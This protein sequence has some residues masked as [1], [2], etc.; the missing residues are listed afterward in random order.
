MGLDPGL[1]PDLPEAVY[2]GDTDS[3]SASSMKLILKSPAQYHY[4]LTH[5]EEPKAHFDVGH[6][7]HAK[8]LGAGA[9]IAVIDVKDKRG[10]AWTEPAEAARAEGK[11]PVT[12]A[13]AEATDAMAEAVLAHPIARRV[14][15]GGESEVSAFWHDEEYG[16]TRRARFDHVNV[17]VI[18]DLK[19]TRDADPKWLPKVVCDY[20]YDVSAAQYLDVARGLGLDVTA[21]ALVFV[22][23]EP[24][25]E[26]VVAELD[27]EFLDRGE[28]LCRAALE[29]F[30]DCR[31]SG[32]WPG[33]T[34]PDDF[35]TLTPPRWANREE[36]SYV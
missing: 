14:L 1:Y 9:P 12:T 26:V 34:G 32:V 16:V 15:T 10:K 30:R 13:E 33:F 8:V 2:F 31:E 5:P 24:P 21:F 22:G 6:A 28:R 36:P 25:H 7:A 11:T 18:G 20:G 35:L 23:K 17:P 29:R 4:R 3:L 19:T 27:A